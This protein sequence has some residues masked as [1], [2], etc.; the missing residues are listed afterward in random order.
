MA[1]SGTVPSA[2]PERLQPTQVAR[3]VRRAT[4]VFAIVAGL[5][6][7]LKFSTRW[8]PASM[9]TVPSIPAGSWVITD[10]WASGLRVGSDVFVT[11]PFGEMLSRVTKLSDDELEVVHP[12]PQ[13][14]WPDSLD[15]GALPRS[16]VQSTIVVVFAP[17]GEGRKSNGK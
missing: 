1:V 4:L 10:R 12:N 7:A 9:N 5:W 14:S 11:T 6:F 2:K 13:S 17:E 15:F 16:N 3:W 8:V